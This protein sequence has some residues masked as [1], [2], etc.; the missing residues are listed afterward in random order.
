M[1]MPS[2]GNGGEAPADM[3]SGGNG[4]E[5][6]SDMPSGDNAAKRLRTC[7]PATAAGRQ[8]ARRAGFTAGDE[9]I[10]FTIDDS[11]VVTLADGHTGTIGDIA[12]DDVLALTLDDSSVAL[13][14]TLHQSGGMDMSTQGG[15]S[16]GGSDTVTN[17]TSA[18]TID[19]DATVTGTTYTSTG[20]DENALRIDGANRHAGRHHD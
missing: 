1:S 4:G 20:D 16:F 6:P 9:T 5:A 14:V 7:R 17:G 12:V 19:A 18:N 8:A 15:A 13:T 10:T 2:G 3:P 11:T